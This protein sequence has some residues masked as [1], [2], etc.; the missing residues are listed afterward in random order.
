MVWILDNESKPCYTGNM[1]TCGRCDTD[2]PE[3]EFSYRNKAKG[4]RTSWCKTCMKAYDRENNQRPE[5]AAQ[6]RQNTKNSIE[7]AR[8]YVFDYLAEHPCED[9]GED[10]PVVLQFDHIDPSTKTGNIADW[11]AQ[12]H[13]VDKI[14]R[15]ITK[16]SVRCANCHLRR[17]AE[18]FGW[19]KINSL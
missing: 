15:E 8:K 3:T 17:T 6:K 7:R 9:C 19:W 18:Q 5:R 10:D 13:G 4:T 11:V 16:C 1:K 14:A 2:K 12:G